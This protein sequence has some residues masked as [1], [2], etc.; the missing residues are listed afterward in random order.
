MQFRIAVLT[1]LVSLQEK[2]NLSIRPLPSTLFGD[3]ETLT[4]APAV[5]FA[6]SLPECSIPQKHT[7]V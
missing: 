5:G 7:E 4:Q 6:C 3:V 2:K 1:G